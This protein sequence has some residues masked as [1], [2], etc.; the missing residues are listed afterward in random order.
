MSGASVASFAF[1]ELHPATNITMICA[2]CKELKCVP[3][4]AGL[5]F[6]ADDP[7][8]VGA[9]LHLNPA[10]EFAADFLHDK[11]RRRALSRWIVIQTLYH[12]ANS[13]SMAQIS[14]KTTFQEHCV[15][16]DAA[17]GK[18]FVGPANATFRLGEGRP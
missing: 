12:A 8:N 18:P 13:H 14:F 6:P 16:K 1:D 5:T 4:P 9:D 2:G 15:R 17:L 11:A 10:A 3:V 7:H